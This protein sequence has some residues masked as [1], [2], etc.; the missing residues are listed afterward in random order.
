VL[1]MDEPCSALDPIAT[2]HV[3]ELMHELREAVIISSTRAPIS[4]M[5]SRT[6]ANSFSYSRSV[7]RR[8]PISMSNGAI[9]QNAP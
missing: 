7:C 3:E 5:R 2:A 1:L 8:S 6:C 4:R 9:S